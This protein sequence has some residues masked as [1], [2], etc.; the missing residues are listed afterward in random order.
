MDSLASMLCLLLALTSTL[1]Y[2]A[3]T[4][5]RR[6][7]NLPPGPQALPLIGNLHQLGLKP[8]KSLSKL[9]ETY[10]PIMTLKLGQ[11]TTIIISNASVAKQVL[12]KQD[13]A[14]A[15]RSIPDSILA[16]DHNKLSVA[17]IPLSPKWREL[18]RICYSHIFSSQKMEAFELTRHHKVHE[19]IAQLGRSAA[20]GEAVLFGDKIFKTLLNLL[21]SI[22]VSCDIVAESESDVG[23]EFRES[24][25]S[26][27]ELAGKPNFVDYFTWL[28]RVDPQRI[29][30]Q[31]TPHFAKMLS[32]SDSI[33]GQRLRQREENGS[34]FESID[35]MD[36]LINIMQ[37][38]SSPELTRNDINHLFVDLFV[39]GTDTTSST[40]EWALSE[41]MKH[42]DTIL[43]AKV[44]LDQAIGKGNQVEDKDILR[45]P[46]LQAIVKETL[47]L[48]PPF[49][50]LL[51]RKNFKE[52]ELLN[53]TIPKDS[54]VMINAWAIGR[55]PSLWECPNDFK[56]ERFLDSEVDVKGGHFELIPFGAGRRICAGLPLA[57]KMIHL[58]L[59]SVINC[60]DWKLQG[61]AK[62]EEE[63][64]MEEEFGLSLQRVQPLRVIPVAV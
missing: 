15:N 4:I 57:H 47:R 33:I 28:K 49:P 32:F 63:L 1:I 17:W 30:A 26:I 62:P 46:Y 3:K 23:K 50:L 52:E 13:Q 51:P 6:R 64:N 24:F 37:D 58:V 61:G 31:M 29:R 2:I 25:R 53:Y 39:A 43:K 54:Q 5:K 14:F 27:M 34:V 59:G 38:S 41:V 21:S 12:Q 8:H 7:T 10:G 22:F 42:P 19:L 11:V 16:C 44:E 56:P 35:V 18:R 48:H 40:L 9:A 20:S 36:A 60:F 55:D 45:L